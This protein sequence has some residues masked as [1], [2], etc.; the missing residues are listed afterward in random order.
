MHAGT[1][2]ALKMHFTHGII[3]WATATC[4]YKPPPFSGGAKFSNATTANHVNAIYSY[5]FT[6]VIYI[7]VDDLV[8]GGIQDSFF[9]VAGLKFKST[10]QIRSHKIK[11]H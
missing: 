1:T 2:A 3:W 7:K 8:I 9:L 11:L 4:R 10:C 5:S 6:P